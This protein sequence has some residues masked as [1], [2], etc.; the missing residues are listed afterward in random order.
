[1][2]IRDHPMQKDKLD[3]V[4]YNLTIRALDKPILAEFFET[5][6][7][8]ILDDPNDY[9]MTIARF[10]VPLNSLPIFIFKIEEGITQNDANKGS[11][12]VSLVH[13]AS[14]DVFT[15][16]LQFISEN[17]SPVPV[18]PSLNNGKQLISQYYYVYAYQHMINMINTALANAFVALQAMH[19]TIY[20]SNPP[21]FY[22]DENSELI[23]LVAQKTYDN[24][25]FFINVSPGPIQTLFPQEIKIYSNT[26]LLTLLDSFDVF[27]EGYNNNNNLTASF[28]IRASPF[29]RNVYFPN[30]VSPTDLLINPTNDLPPTAFISSTQEYKSLIF[31]NSFRNLLFVTNTIPI[32]NEYLPT[33]NSLNNPLQ[34]EGINNFFPI[35]TDFE[36]LLE[37]AGNTRGLLNYVADGQYRLTDMQSNLPLRKFD[38]KLFW[39][40]QDNN[41]YP[42]TLFPYTQIKIKFLFA[43]KELFNYCIEC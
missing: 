9:Y 41:L 11:Y 25:G 38:I 33:I 24:D 40:D 30:N 8:I 27:F 26:I 14:G 4:Y 36:P 2:R 21:F 34:G 31:W 10:T 39:V 3:N 1:M 5:R 18:P 43:R 19:P 28:N 35:L 37:N 7:D 6:Q 29:N 23:S 22:Y 20:S 12:S 16:N 17:L 42:L 32:K 13:N 15:E